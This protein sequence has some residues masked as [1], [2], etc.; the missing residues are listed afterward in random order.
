VILYTLEADISSSWAKFYPTSGPN[1]ILKKTCKTLDYQ[2]I[3]V[4]QAATEDIT[5]QLGRHPRLLPDIQM[6][7]ET[8]ADKCSGR[9]TLRW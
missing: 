4:R 3:Q 9:N 5:D 8:F 1:S 7:S 2:D 6:Q